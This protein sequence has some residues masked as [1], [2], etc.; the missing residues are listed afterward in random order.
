M[1]T[2]GQSPLLARGPPSD[3]SGDTEEEDALLTGERTSKEHHSNSATSI[4][5]SR[6]WKEIGL[7]VWALVAT[8]AVVIL[9]AVYQHAV[10]RN[11]D[12]RGSGVGDAGGG[13]PSGKRNLIFMVSDGMG[14]TSM[15]MTRNWLQY[16]EQSPWD[17]ALVL[18]EYLIGQSRTRSTSSL[19]TDSA[20]GATA[21]SCG[22]KSYNG[23]ISILPDHSPCG[24]VMEAAKRKGYTTGLVVTTRITDATPAVFASHARRREMEDGIALQMIGSAHPLGR[25]LDLMLGGGR[26]HFVPNGSDGSCRAD[27]VDVRESAKEKGW[28]YISTREDFDKLGTNVELPL[29]GLFAAGDIPYEVDRRYQNATFPSIEEM[30]R[31]ALNALSAA[32]KD[33]DQGFFVMIEG[34]RIDHAGHA[35]DPAAQVHEVLAYDRTVAAVL[36]FI[37]DSETPTLMVSTSDHETG[38]L[39]TARQLHQEYP[40]Y[41]WYPSVLAN[42]SHS[43]AY[44]SHAYH[45]HLS[46]LPSASSLSTALASSEG[47]RTYLISLISDNLGINDATDEELDTL[48]QHPALAAYVFADMVSRRAQTGWS[49]HGHSGA[50]VNIYS[51]DHKAAERLIGN[52]ENTDVG[53]FLRW[54][55]DVEDE[56]EKVTRELNEYMKDGSADSSWLG[57]VPGEDERLDGQDHLDHYAGDHRRREEQRSGLDPETQQKAPLTTRAQ[58][59]VSMSAS[60]N[61]PSDEETYNPRGRTP[62]RS[63]IPVAE[64]RKIPVAER[65]KIPV[66]ERRRIDVAERR[67]RPV[68]GRGEVPVPQLPEVPVTHQHQQSTA[69]CRS[70][71]AMTYHHTLFTG[72]PQQRTSSGLLLAESGEEFSSGS[73]TPTSDGGGDARARY[74]ALLAEQEELVDSGENVGR[75]EMARLHEAV[76][77]ARGELE[78]LSAVPTEA[79]GLAHEE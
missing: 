16:T 1:A 12:S 27:D 23:A 26:C 61:Q 15:E 14:P 17:A 32:T 59:H 60:M 18:D 21:F 58:Q 38:G 57:T 46:S 43:G 51:S 66:A 42:V 63:R 75:V 19:V 79:E 45:A 77:R 65:R 71:P 50:D 22:L 44:L 13:R 67:K 11:S 4:V 54:Y 53:E 64:R 24:S 37:K 49:T 36:D 7:L 6:R 31:T 68:A 52:R 74:D 76:L 30:A 39:A 34:S 25:M 8:A 40:R 47:T 10:S 5:R 73:T 28:S 35:N 33:S 55:L 3:H 62:S 9:A 72:F 78:G 48:L 69:G 70:S 20:A 41:L 29:L 56:V 2:R